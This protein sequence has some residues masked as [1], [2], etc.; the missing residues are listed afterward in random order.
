MARKLQSVCSIKQEHHVMILMI[1]TKYS[2]TIPIQIL[3]DFESTTTVIFMWSFLK[4]YAGCR[5]YLKKRVVKLMVCQHLKV[6]NLT[7]VGIFLE[8]GIS[9]NLQIQLNIGTT[10][11]IVIELPSR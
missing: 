4:I 8:L 3:G 6:T 1:L 5:K 11:R 2:E 9:K 7:E 10:C